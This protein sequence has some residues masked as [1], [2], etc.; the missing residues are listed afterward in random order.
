MHDNNLNLLFYVIC[1]TMLAYHLILFY[2]KKIVLFFNLDLLVR[3]RFYRSSSTQ[4][5]ISS[6][7][8][9]ESKNLSTLII[10]TRKLWM[11]YSFKDQLFT[12]TFYSWSLSC[13]IRS[14]RLK[15]MKWKEEINSIVILVVVVKLLKTTR[16]L[17]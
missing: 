11:R 3:S 17:S 16:V 13:S 12:P 14:K 6:K 9:Y 4:W 7:K 5:V 8:I 1:C 10:K 15:K 2:L